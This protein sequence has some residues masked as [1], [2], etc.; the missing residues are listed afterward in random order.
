MRCRQLIYAAERMD[1]QVFM[2]AEE[3][4]RLGCKVKEDHG[5]LSDQY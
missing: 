4:I 3:R 2:E 5:S 1:D